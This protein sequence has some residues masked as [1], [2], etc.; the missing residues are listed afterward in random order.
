M[1]MRHDVILG[2]MVLV[3]GTSSAA[4][5]GVVVTSTQTKFDTHEV[6]QTAIYVE[7]DRLKVV[8]P[9]RVVVFRG[10][11]NRLWVID[12][13]RRSYSEMTPESM[14][15]MGS[16]MAGAQ[17]QMGAA[18]AQLQERMAQMPPEQRAMMMQ[19]LA[20]RGLGNGAP[21]APP[22]VAYTRAGGSKTIASWRCDV[23]KKTVNGQQEEDV[24]ITPISSAGLTANDFAVLDRISQFMAPMMSSPMMPRVDYLSLNEMNKAVGFQGMP[25]DTTMYEQGKPTSQSTVVKLERTTI[26]ANT[27]D[28]PAGLT[29]RDIGM[30]PPR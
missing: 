10:D 9:E 8:T 29:K 22:Q 20:G 27:F 30:P 25:L 5:A 3:L 28:L 12:T 23:Y 24:C 1:K 13:Q 4:M 19:M 18:A 2:V 6:S 14:Q 7:P 11:M 26:P 21:P 17:A 16:R 15:A